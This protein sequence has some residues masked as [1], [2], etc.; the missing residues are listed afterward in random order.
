MEQH[1]LKEN[2]P[3]HKVAFS[4]SQFLSRCGQIKVHLPRS[5]QDEGRVRRMRKQSKKSLQIWLHLV[6]AQMICCNVDLYALVRG[7]S[8]PCTD[9]RECQNRLRIGTGERKCGYILLVWLFD[10]SRLGVKRS[11]SGRRCAWQ[12]TWRAS[13]LGGR[14]VTITHIDPLRWKELN[15]RAMR[16]FSIS[17]IVMT[18]MLVLTKLISFCHGKRS[19]GQLITG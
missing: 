9:A 6:H 16:T 3:P 7:N 2:K 18:G 14:K 8:S 15:L 17:T 13:R 1:R 4:T 10:W 11:L 12:L 5:G 19:V